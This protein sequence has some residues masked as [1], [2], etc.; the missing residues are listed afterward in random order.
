MSAT[1][2]S[3]FN[4]HSNRIEEVLNKNIEMFLPQLDPVWEETVVTNQ[5]IIPFDQVGRDMLYIKTYMGSLAG[6]IEPDASVRKDF[7]LYGDDQTD[8]GFNGTSP[9]LA[10]LHTQGLDNVWPDA[11][12][13]PM[14]KPYQLA[15]PMRAMITNLMLTL[16]EMQAEATPA[17]IGEVIGPKMEGFA[18]NVAHTLCNYWYTS[19][20][21]NYA[22]CTFN[23]SVD[24]TI[25]TYGNTVNVIDIVNHTD[26]AGAI[27]RFAVGQMIDI[28]TSGNARRNSVGSASGARIRIFVTAVDELAG[29]ISVCA[30]NL[31]AHTSDTIALADNDYIVLAT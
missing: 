2:N 8:A 31:A 12:K 28:Y 3:L 19:Q 16:G 14:A 7:V 15:V 11:T 13:G 4:T 1:T 27:D 24:D 20:N 17:F 10:K 30:E 29:T 26:E 9:T 18:K 25:E 5:G 23:S 6:V 22:L 21:S